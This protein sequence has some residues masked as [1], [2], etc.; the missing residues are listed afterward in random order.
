M[1]HATATHEKGGQTKASRV[2]RSTSSHKGQKMEH[3]DAA[4]KV[5]TPL[6]DFKMLESKSLL[7][8]HGLRGLSQEHAEELADRVR[9]AGGR[10]IMPKRGMLL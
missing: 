2:S 6:K 4:A 3:K 8:V 9:K 7:M 5:T 10:V 1:K